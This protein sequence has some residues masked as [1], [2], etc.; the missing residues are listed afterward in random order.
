MQVGVTYSCPHRYPLTP[1]YKLSSSS[2]RL[3]Q[4]QGVVKLRK[5]D[6]RA[7]L[8]SRSQLERLGGP[9]QPPPSGLTEPSSPT[10]LVKL[11]SSTVVCKTM[12]QLSHNGA[13]GTV[14]AFKNLSY[15]K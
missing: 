7:N 14:S 8:V 2:I 5:E 4:L 12:W 6:L 3:N 10:F 9:P 15:L 13:H 11:A 1:L